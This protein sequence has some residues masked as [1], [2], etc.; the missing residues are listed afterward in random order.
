VHGNVLKAVA[1]V[2]MS[3]MSF[4]AVLCA[5]APDRGFGILGIVF[6]KG[7]FCAHSPR[8][9]RKVR[10]IVALKSLLF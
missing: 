2:V 3:S 4:T 10:Q 1:I 7:L 5:M 9:A 6:L 8:G